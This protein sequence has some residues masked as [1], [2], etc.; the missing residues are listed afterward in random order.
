MND[1][2]ETGFHV[3][4]AADLMEVVEQAKR[5]PAPTIPDT[6]PRPLTW[7]SLVECEPLLAELRQDVER[8]KDDGGDSF[9]NSRVWFLDGY[10]ERMVGLVGWYSESP[11]EVMRTD[12]AYETTYQ[13]LYAIFPACR[14]CFCL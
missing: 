5:H 10:K 6:T 7:E 1:T 14:N 12:D 4:S 3:L 2:D 9:C 11:Y 13:T 8:V